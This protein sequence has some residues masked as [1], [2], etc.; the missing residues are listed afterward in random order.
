MHIAV[1]GRAS[2]SEQHVG[3]GRGTRVAKVVCF[4]GDLTS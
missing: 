2:G 1:F 4:L 3:S